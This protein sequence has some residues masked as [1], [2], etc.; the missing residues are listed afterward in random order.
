MTDFADLVSAKGAEWFADW[1]TLLTRL[2]NATGAME[3]E[4]ETSS[5]SLTPSVASKAFTCDQVPAWTVGAIVRAQSAGDATHYMIGD[6]TSIVG[7]VLTVN[8]TI[9]NGGTAKTD[10]VITYPLPS[11]DG[12][13]DANG[14]FLASAGS[15]SAAAA[16]ANLALLGNRAYMDFS[17]GKARIGAAAGGGAAVQTAI[18]N[19]A[20]EVIVTDATSADKV[21]HGGNRFAGGLEFA[22]DALGS[23]SSTTASILAAGEEVITAT[24]GASVIFD[25][26]VPAADHHYLKTLLI[27]QDGTGARTPTFKRATATSQIQWVTTEPTWSGQAAGAVTRV[28][29]QYL[30][31]WLYLTAVEGLET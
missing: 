13:V 7:S 15:V 20:T 4:G 12:L 6:V 29:A 5:T 2:T 28:T 27:T 30:G 9:A 21:I 26:G 25:F 8:V 3:G 22:D 11:S 14:D 18:V 16:D 24:I 31:G 1:N 17:A 10:W 23:I 19:G